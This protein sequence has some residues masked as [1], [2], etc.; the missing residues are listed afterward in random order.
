MS[1]IKIPARMRK[2]PVYK[3]YVV[4]YT[5]FIDRDGVPDFKI[6]DEVKRTKCVLHGRCAMCGEKLG[7]RIA[8][9]G[10]PASIEEGKLFIDAGMHPDC[11]KYAWD[12]CPYIV[13]GT[14][15]ATF[16]KDH[17]KDGTVTN[18]N[19]I[20][21][22]QAPPQRMGMMITTAY[23]VVAVQNPETGRTQLAVKAGPALEVIWR[24]FPQ[25]AGKV[26][27]KAE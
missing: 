14:G 15:H 23:A 6:N 5:T 4:S 19:V 18:L 22:S 1:E 13:M 20:A 3:G 26:E 24:T 11:A 9:I 2:N 16:L 17:S 10:G 25:N 7:K 27:E 12:V 8:F 21:T